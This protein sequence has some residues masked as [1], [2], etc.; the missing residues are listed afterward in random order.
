MVERPEAYRWSS[1]RAHV[2][3]AA[4]SWLDIDPGYLGLGS[5]LAERQTRYAQWVAE[6]IP[7]GEWDLIRRAIHRGQLTGD[8]PFVDVIAQ[9]TGR[10]LVPH[11]PGRPK[12]EREKGGNTSV[13]ISA[14]PFIRST[15]GVRAWKTPV[16]PGRGVVFGTTRRVLRGLDQ[17]IG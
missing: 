2:G 15:E 7:A 16:L 8:E 11:G 4:V 17:R 1:Y 12:A 13:P 5:T 6:G 3:T 9:R 14:F 10:R